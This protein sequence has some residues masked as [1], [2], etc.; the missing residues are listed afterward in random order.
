MKKKIFVLSMDAMVGEDLA[1]LRNKPNFS[2]L[3]ARCAQVER[4][5]TVYPSITY[6]A[7][8][9][10]MTGC[11]P[12]KHGIVTNTEFR[13]TLGEPV[14]W[15]LYS[16]ALKVEDVFAAAKRAG[17]TTASVYWPIC[18]N[19]PNIDWLINEF[20]FYENEDLE[21]TFAGFGANE[22]T[23]EVVRE[24][25]H[26][27]PVPKEQRV[28]EPQLNH[29]FDDFIMGCTCSLIRRHQPDFMMVHNCC[30]DSLRHRYGIFNSY[31]TAGLDQ[32]DKWLGEVM[33]AMEE[34]GVLEQ[35]NFILLSDHGQMD[36]ARR[37]KVNVLLRRAG[38]VDVDEEG[39]VTDWR[40]FSQSNGMSAT[41]FLKDIEDKALWQQVY[42]HL[43]DLASQGVWGFDKV[44]TEPEVKERYGQYGDFAFMLETDGYTAFS[45]DWCEPVINPVDLSDY[46]LGKATHGYEPEKGPQPVFVAAG[47]DFLPGAYIADALTLDEAP[48]MA[49]ILGQT[50]L[51]AEGRVLHELLVK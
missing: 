29:E 24:N 46:R 17:C 13:T 4:M 23:L 25:K 6:P 2:R 9:S 32:T 11:R 39:V 8:M 50:M 7:H 20:F 30:L 40:A 10:M 28:G 21:S 1:Y 26:R 47:P 19:N 38:L 45:D 3:F 51:Q 16:S 18:G 27:F 49:A 15:H 43:Q 33:D 14:P 44:Y 36:F 22:E 12:G 48:T 34:A 31:V 35:T 5:R 42:D 41:I 37:I